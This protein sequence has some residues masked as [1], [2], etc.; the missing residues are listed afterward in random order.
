MAVK[1]VAHPLANIAEIGAKPMAKET[2]LRTGV[3][4]DDRMTGIM[5]AQEVYTTAIANA[6]SYAGY[7]TRIFELTQEARASFIE[8]IKGIL[9]DAKKAN[10]LHGAVDNRT[11]AR[12]VASATVQVS[13]LSIIAKAWNAGA[14]VAGMLKYANTKV[15]KQDKMT[16]D[17]VGFTIITEYA[18]QYLK[19]NAQ[20][21]TRGRGVKPGIEKLAKY[22]HDLMADPKMVEFWA[23]HQEDKAA[24]EK[25]A[26]VVAKLAPKTEE[27]GN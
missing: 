1:T 7:A 2:A 26:V 23:E 5:L 16:A 18:R 8:N 11:A 14:T 21:D 9:A 3:A 27:K 6:Q 22:V 24:C 10:T 13:Q 20:G 25:V 15:G 19:A 4:L 12:R 17:D